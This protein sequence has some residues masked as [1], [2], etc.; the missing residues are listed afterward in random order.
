MLY[1]M[2]HGQTDFNKEHRLQGGTDIPL[3]D[4]GRQM[5]RDAS[6][7][8]KDIH[9]DI[10]FTS[11][12]SRARETAKIFLEGR[13]VPVVVDERMKEMGFGKFEGCFGRELKSEDSVYVLMNEPQNYV[14]ADG[15]ESFESIYGRL[16][17]F[18]NEKVRPE[19]LAGKD[20]LIVGHGTVNLC[21]A[22]IFDNT[23][24][25]H[26]WD[27]IMRNCDVVAV[28][29]EVLKNPVKSPF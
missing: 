29:P 8:F 4:N 15:S 28:D 22:N 12:L 13:E 23:P 2:R 20:V 14:P 25:E 6:E 7:K 21:I 10:C 27:G 11:P 24:M 5:A 9:F 26:F 17:A 1:L 18:L 19:I 16:V 3:N